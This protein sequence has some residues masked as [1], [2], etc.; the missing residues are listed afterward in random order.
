MP[1]LDPFLAQIVNWV[2]NMPDEALLDLVRNHLGGFHGGGRSGARAVAAFK[3][4]PTNGRRGP[5]KV[6]RRR[7]ATSADKEQALSAVERAV[8]SSKGLSASEIVSRTKLPKA[9]VQAAVRELKHSK[10][11]FQG[12][13]RRFARYAG[14]AKTAKQASLN[15][16]K[17]AAGPRRKKK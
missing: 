10:R 9:R 1:N 12:G 17:S 13:D 3:I 5:R 4:G 11:I 2:R 7:R 14:D 16:R 8:K 15:A 6:K